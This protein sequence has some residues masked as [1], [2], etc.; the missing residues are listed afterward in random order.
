MEI[1]KIILAK[2]D[3]SDWGKAL[4]KIQDVAEEVLTE[5]EFVEYLHKT[6]RDNRACDGMDGQLFNGEY[7]DWKE[8][9]YKQ[10]EIVGAFLKY[11]SEDQL[12]KIANAL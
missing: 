3:I 5:K 11:F 6:H 1:E 10:K 2:V 9:G 12:Q 8:F 4:N 7:F